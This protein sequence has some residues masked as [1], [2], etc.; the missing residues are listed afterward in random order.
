MTFVTDPGTGTYIGSTLAL[1]S[2]TGAVLVAAGVA[3]VILTVETKVEAVTA[4]K[5]LVNIKGVMFIDNPIDADTTALATWAQAN[6]V[7]YYDV[8]DS[9]DN[10]EKDPTDVVWATKLS[11]L[12][13]CRMLFS[14]AGNRK[15]ATGYMSRA[16][17]VNF[18]AENSAITMHLKEIRGVAAEAYTQSEIAKAKAVGLDIYTTIKDVAVV[19]TSGAN[20]F[21]DNRYNI[22]AFI[23]AVQTDMFNLLKQTGT[24]I[25]QTVRGVNQLIDQGE[26]TTRGFVRAGVFAPGTWSS[27]DF[28]GDLDTFNRSIS[29]NGFYWMAGRL[30]DQPQVDRQNR[31]APVI[32]AAVKNAGAIHSVDII[33][34]FNI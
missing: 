1:A 24:K 15:L 16:H 31:K 14:A 7:L 25:P 13:N 10:L 19:L 26:K 17:T 30:S 4:L 22:I 32:Q 3:E 12:T 6:S 28:F 9:A 11:G 23:D 5:A 18:N 2:G 33:I 20:D 29:S 27:P 21:M 34:N 8:F